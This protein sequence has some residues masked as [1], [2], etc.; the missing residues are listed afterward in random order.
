MQ[1]DRCRRCRLHETL[2]QA[3]ERSTA[4][5]KRSLNALQPG[6]GALF[7]IAQGGTDVALRRAHIEAL[8]AEPFDGLALGGLAVGESPAEMYDTIEAVAPGMPK[9]RRVMGVGRPED[10]LEAITQGST[11]STASPTE[12]AKRRRLHA[13]RKDEPATRYRYDERPIDEHCSCPACSQHSRAYIHH[14]L[15]AKEVYEFA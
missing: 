12:R 7:A 6:D 13:A 4:W 10:I 3:V 14:L 5:A 8:A 1:L 2:R 15:R 11:C 9:H